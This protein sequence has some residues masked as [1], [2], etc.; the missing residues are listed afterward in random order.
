MIVQPC[1]INECPCIDC[2]KSLK[3]ISSATAASWLGENSW[4]LGLLRHVETCRDMLRHVETLGACLVQVLAAFI[5]SHRGASTC[6]A[7]VRLVVGGSPKCPFL[8]CRVCQGFS[9]QKHPKTHPSA[10]R[11]VILQEH[12]K[13]HQT[14]ILTSIHV[15]K[16]SEQAGYSVIPKSPSNPAKAGK[17]WTMNQINSNHL[18]CRRCSQNENSQSTTET[19]RERE[20]DRLD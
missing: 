19:E 12:K 15:Q 20:I 16:T 1:A 6:P 8:L 7:W 3:L 4:D 11:A 9:A 13:G 10:N 14:S 18:K 17:T 5:A 2:D